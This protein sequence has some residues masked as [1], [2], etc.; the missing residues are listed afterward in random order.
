MELVVTSIS[1]P[2]EPTMMQCLMANVEAS[3]VA[4][5]NV[6]KD[7]QAQTAAL[8]AQT[9]A[10]V[11]LGTTVERGFQGVTAL[12]QSILQMITRNAEAPPQQ[13]GSSAM[14]NRNIHTKEENHV[15]YIKGTLLSG[16]VDFAEVFVQE[17]LPSESFSSAKSPKVCAKF[18]GN[19]HDSF[20]LRE[21]NTPALFHAPNRLKG[22]LLGDKEY[23][24]QT[25][26][27]IAVRK[28][29]NKE[30]QRYNDSHITTRSVI[31]QAIGMLKM[32]SR[33]LDRSGGALHY[34][35]VHVCRIIVM[36]CVLHNIGQ[37]RGLQV[38]ELQCA[39]EASTSASNNEEKEEE[40][41]DEQPIGRAVPHLAARDARESLI[42]ERFS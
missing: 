9:A 28:P 15:F 12:Q 18:P 10:F 26:L 8:E 30:Q 27:M 5:T 37:Q 41:D 32:R 14:A 22:W 39:H 4:Q 17:L 23:P 24:L 16:F 20:I 35:P 7:L 34:S 40:D 2:V 6:I 36:C 29:T 31:E 21:S 3:I 42:F 19:C 11:A 33:C 13:S 38:E 1:A 25:W